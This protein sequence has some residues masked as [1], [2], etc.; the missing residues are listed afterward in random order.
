MA[1]GDRTMK[2][3]ATARLPPVCGIQTDR[4]KEKT[5]KRKRNT[6]S[7]WVRETFQEIA[8]YLGQKRKDRECTG[9]NEQREES[10]SERQGERREAEK[11]KSALISKL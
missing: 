5:P 2:N 8:G 3:P 9:W 10:G 1:F 7:K 4:G 11:M 6:S